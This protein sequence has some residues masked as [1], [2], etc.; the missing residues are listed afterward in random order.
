MQVSKEDFEKVLT[1]YGRDKLTGDTTG[2]CDPPITRYHDFSGGKK[3]PDGR[4]AWIVR[5]GYMPEEYAAPDEYF[6]ED[7]FAHLLPS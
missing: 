6:I 5:N 7:E 4:V 3:W 1:A 2:I